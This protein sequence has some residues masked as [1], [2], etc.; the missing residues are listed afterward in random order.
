MIVQRII[1]AQVV[2]F[3]VL[4]GAAGAATTRSQVA[5]EAAEDIRLLV[6]ELE[7]RHPNPY[8]SVPRA[9]FERQ[10]DDLIA[11]LP[12]LDENQVLVELMR[13]TVLG[14]RDGHTG[15]FPGLHRRDMHRYPLRL[16]YFADGLHVVR[17]QGVPGAVGWKLVAVNGLALPDLEALVRPLVPGDN[18]WSRLNLMPGYL[19]TAEVLHGLRVI[20]AV[21]RAT[22][23][24]ESG[25]GER[26]DVT[27]EPTLTAPRYDATLGLFFQPPVRAGIPRKRLPESFRSSGQARY[28]GRIGRSVYFAYNNTVQSTD[29]I[30]EKLRR[31]MRDRRV[32]RLVIDLRWNGGGNNRTLPN[33]MYLLRSRSVNRQGKLVVLI[34]R[35]TFSAAQNFVNQLE[36]GTRVTFVGEPT[37]GSPNHYSGG[38]Q[39]DLPFLGLH[40][41]MSIGYYQDTFA[42]DPRLATEPHVRVALGSSDFM[43]GR[44]PVLAKAL[45]LR[46]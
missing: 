13:L 14:D 3:V 38:G 30:V 5:P 41:G 31:L 37:G 44:D 26:R 36:R 39:F 17:A 27:L 42:G 34:G 1:L 35:A 9:E 8:H 20:P 11:R 29:E 23:T 15:M 4:A 6:R 10:V 40:G 45:R 24:L 19:V 28:I 32:R 33:L 21:G 16:Y 7:A 22:F 18:Q 12:Q 43:A 46:R 25:I 2:A